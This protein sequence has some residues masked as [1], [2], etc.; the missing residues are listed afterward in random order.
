[1]PFIDPT[2]TPLDRPMDT[3]RKSGV[4]KIIQQSIPN[5][6]LDEY[7]LFVDFLDAYYEWLD[8]RG[9]P[10]EVLQNGNKYFD[11][12]STSD[13]FL[14]YFKSSFLDGF[15][16]RMAIAD[17]KPFDERT[18][19]KNIREFYKMKGCEK[20]IQLLFKLVAGSDSI[21]EYPR[22]YIFSLSSGNYKD[23]HILYALKDYTNISNGF[24]A[25]GVHGLQINQYEGV[26]EL[27]ATATIDQVYEIKHNNKEY[28]VFRVTNAT[29]TFVQSDEIPLILT[30]GGTE[31]EFYAM[32]SITGL[33]VED[34]GSGYSVGEFF[35]IGEPEE[36]HIR[37]FISETDADG[38]IKRVILLSNPPDYGGSSQITIDSPVGSGAQLTINR[39]VLSDIIQDYKDN[40]NLLSKVSKIQDS[41]EY[42]QFSYVIKSKRS[43]EE[44]IDAIKTVI[45]PSG[46]VLFNALYDNIYTIRPSYY[47]TRVLGFENTSIGSYARFTP[48]STTGGIILGGW[49]PWSGSGDPDPF[50]QWGYIFSKWNDEGPRELIPSGSDPNIPT[51]PRALPNAQGAVANYFSGQFAPNRTYLPN[52]E[53]SQVEGITVW[54]AMPHP[55]TRGMPTV[56]P[57]TPF[58]A[59]KLEEVLRM[60]VPLIGDA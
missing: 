39:G 26:T 52:P 43:L 45:H 27:I 22:D 41:L 54:I 37:G 34:G 1:M 53:Q 57:G 42:Q 17:G 7:P 50:K 25:D 6:V 36:E 4:S 24:D 47:A 49:N 14:Q 29:G 2:T 21:I 13:E 38:K 51:P 30:Q 19:L 28:L 59:M 33:S 31:F 9:N 44:Y 46:F 48:Q 12:D 11:V 16:K 10:I 58:A 32:S 18:L 5:F 20:S 40:K 35:T 3:T 23:Y 15:P 55:A 60:P 56:P 8:Q